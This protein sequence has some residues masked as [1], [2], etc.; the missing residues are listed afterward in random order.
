MGV[1]KRVTAMAVVVSI[2]FGICHGSIQFFYTLLLPSSYRMSYVV[3]A[4]SN[5]IVLFNSEVNP[6]VYALLNHNFRQKVKA[7]LRCSKVKVDAT[8]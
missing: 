4:I 6:F 1:R 5:Q 7:I 2:I 8:S 3:Y